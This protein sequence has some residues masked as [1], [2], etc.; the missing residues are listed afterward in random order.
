MV[1][2]AAWQFNPVIDW[3]IQ[4]QGSI[5]NSL[6]GAEI[7]A[8]ADGDER[9][10]HVKNCVIKQYT[11]RHVE[12]TLH[13]D[14]RGLFDTILLR[15]IKGREYSLRQTVLRIRDSFEAGEA[16]IILWVQK[17]ANIAD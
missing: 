3:T 1:S 11:G 17:K 2:S 13:V 12:H 14:S 16:N 10:L 15:P 8:F 7:L 5:Y 9:K 6:D 4:K